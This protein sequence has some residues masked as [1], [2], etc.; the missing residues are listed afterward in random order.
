MVGL[1]D[2]AKEVI[3]RALLAECEPPHAPQEIARVLDEYD[4]RI[5][6]D[7]NVFSK[8]LSI[9]LNASDLD[10]ASELVARQ[11][12]GITRFEFE[13]GDV[14]HYELIRWEVIDKTRSKVV[15]SSQ[16]RNETVSHP[17]FSYTLQL[18]GLYCAKGLPEVGKVD[19]NIGDHGYAP[20]LAFSDGRPD[21]FLV[22]DPN[23]LL[24]KGYAA[25]RC[26]FEAND[27]AWAQREPIAFWR[28]GTSGY[29]TDP[30]VGWRSLP[31]IR[32]CDIAR[33]R[34]DLIDAGISH[35][36]QTATDEQVRAAGYMRPRAPM[37]AFNKYKYQID[38]DGNTNSWPG[39][40]Q[41]LLS[42]SPVLKVKSREG[43]RQW[44]YDRL[45]PWVNFVPVASD[46]SDLV[47][48]IYGCRR[49]TTPRARLASTARRWPTRLIIA[50]KSN[51]VRRL[52]RL[53]CDISPAVRR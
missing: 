37:E 5:R 52:S 43:Y 48:K 17:Y 27:I 30:V 7:D 26:A 22:P 34:P 1:T 3:E 24:H 50:A 44:F 25:L 39:L 36:V 14:W 10:A 49:M 47:D 16:F 33:D 9:A 21:Y 6:S 19:I 23:F 45:K 20:G 31:R 29:P 12:G 40:F 15:I 35:A 11:Y 18:L 8:V 28:G 51:A 13:F 42:G 46:M 32:L 2:N 38:I 53:R 41:K 4:T